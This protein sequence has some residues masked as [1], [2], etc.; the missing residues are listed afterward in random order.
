MSSEDQTLLRSA[1]AWLLRSAALL[2]TGVLLMLVAHLVAILGYLTLASLGAT[3]DFPLI[4]PY[5][6]GYVVLYPAAA[7]VAA[8]RSQASWQQIALCL[9]IPPVAYFLTLGIVESKWDASSGAIWGALL[10][11]VLTA[12]VAFFARSPVTAVSPSGE[13]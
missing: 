11:L 7:V 4:P 5:W 9:C 13:S 2:G 10:A 6:W 8:R 12:I 1:A 3:D